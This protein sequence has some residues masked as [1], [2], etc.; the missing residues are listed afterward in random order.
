MHKASEFPGTGIG[1]ATVQRVVHRH[2]GSVWA[3]AKVDQG[4]TLYFTLSPANP[5]PLRAPTVIGDGI[6]ET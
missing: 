4:C 1:L 5:N 6:K 3:D 2:G